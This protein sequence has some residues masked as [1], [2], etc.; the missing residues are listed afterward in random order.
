MSFYGLLFIVASALIDPGIGDIVY[1]KCIRVL[2]AG[3]AITVGYS[4][5]FIALFLSTLLLG[6]AINI[7][8]IVGSLLTFLG[9]YFVFKEDVNRKV[10]LKKVFVGFIPAIAW[11]VGSV[12][13]KFFKLW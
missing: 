7:N 10:D 4:Y 6:E 11:G 9:I 1:I 5:I 2:G 8:L 3:R 13:N 12:V